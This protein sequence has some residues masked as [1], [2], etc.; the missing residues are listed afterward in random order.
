MDSSGQVGVLF[1]DRRD[2]PANFLMHVFVARSADGGAT[3][4]E[5]RITR[6][7]FPAIVNQ[8]SG[9]APDYMGDY[10]GLAADAS[11]AAVGF[12]AAWGDNSLGR[13]SVRASRVLFAP[14]PLAPAE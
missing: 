8:D 10:I 4:A 9:T 3:W 12:M 2:D 7:S 13:Q 6:Q 14:V 11:G 5:R 1:C